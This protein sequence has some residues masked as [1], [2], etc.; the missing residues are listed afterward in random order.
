M[1]LTLANTVSASR[2]KVGYPYPRYCLFVYVMCGSGAAREPSARQSRERGW[3]LQSLRATSVLRYVYGYVMWCFLLLTLFVTVQ[4]R[5]VRMTFF[6]FC[7]FTY[8]QHLSQMRIN[9]NNIFINLI[10]YDTCIFN[11]SIKLSLF[12]II[13]FFQNFSLFKTFNIYSLYSLSGLR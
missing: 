1:T 9:K 13:I 5:A 8:I 12:N 7:S 3:P 2:T 11:K 4:G 10:L 6:F